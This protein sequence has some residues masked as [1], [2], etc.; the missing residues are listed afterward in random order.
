MSGEIPAWLG[1][2]S[3]LTLLS[4]GKNKLSGEIPAELGS[5]SNLTLLSFGKNKLSGEIPAELGS[6]HL[7]YLDVSQN[8]LSG[9]VPN[10]LEVWLHSSSKLGGLPFC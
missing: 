10:S 2:L 8:D 3:N 6:L 5:L 9:C 7:R 4:F 1:S